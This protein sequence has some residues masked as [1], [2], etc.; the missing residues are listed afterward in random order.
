MKLYTEDITQAMNARYGVDELDEETIK[1][2][3]DKAEK[4]IE[5]FFRNESKAVEPF[6]HL[7]IAEMLAEEEEIED[8]NVDEA[9]DMIAVSFADV[10][11]A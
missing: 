11:D 8:I 6:I 9:R 3:K 2:I 7:A 5:Q 10:L 4:A 1:K